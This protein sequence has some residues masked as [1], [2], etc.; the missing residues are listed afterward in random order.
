[1]VSTQRQ[2]TMTMSYIVVDLQDNIKRTEENA[3]FVVSKKLITR[4]E[5]L[6]YLNSL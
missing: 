4:E 2:I 1:M 3:V 5:A 6:G